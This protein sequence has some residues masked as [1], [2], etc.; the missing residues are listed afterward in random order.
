MKTTAILANAVLVTG[1]ICGCN[2]SPQQAEEP[3]PKPAAATAPAAVD[4]TLRV[5]V[6]CAGCIYSVDGVEG[7]SVLAAKIDDRVVVA[8]GE[9]GDIHGDGLCMQARKAEVVGRIEGDKL[10]IVSMKLDKPGD[11]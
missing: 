9:V 7:C 2:K 8:S 6:G 4:Q 10:V 1:I 3:P 5:E 11:G